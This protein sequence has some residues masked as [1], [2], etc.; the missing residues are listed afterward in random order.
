MYNRETRTCMCILLPG[1]KF[2]LGNESVGHF[3]SFWCDN[4]MSGLSYSP[5]CVRP[6]ITFLMTIT[7][8]R[9]VAFSCKS[10]VS[11]LPVIGFFVLFIK[12]DKEF[13]GKRLKCK[14]LFKSSCINKQKKRKEEEK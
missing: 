6:L 4:E 13:K 14:T 5:N 8:H 1:D 11:P 2:A 3:A 9:S 7:E 10:K 12:R